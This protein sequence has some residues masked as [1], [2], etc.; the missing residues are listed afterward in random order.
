MLFFFSDPSFYRSQ[1]QFP[2]E[3]T[4][5]SPTI[6]DDP[7]FRFFRDCIGVVDGTHIRAFT[8]LEDQPHMHNQK[9]YLSQNCLFI[10]DFDFFF[11]Y[12]LTGWDGSTADANLWNN[13]HTQ[14]LWMPWGKYL[15]AD[16]GFGT[17][18]ALLV[19]YRGVQYH[20]KEWCQASQRYV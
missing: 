3:N 19:P 11:I 1:V 17:S 14:D 10:C 4:P 15:L 6:T 16:A 5:I 2:T 7:R 13:A 18:D 8:A 20:L 12:T 9:G